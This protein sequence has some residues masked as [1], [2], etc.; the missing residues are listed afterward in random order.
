MTRHLDVGCGL[1][2][3]SRPASCDLLWWHVTCRRSLVAAAGLL[4]SSDGV[5]A[6]IDSVAESK[7]KGD[8]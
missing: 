7:N 8:G 5:T 3:C 6:L 2:L 4:L 1:L